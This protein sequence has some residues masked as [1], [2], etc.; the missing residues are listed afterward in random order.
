MKKLKELFEDLDL[1]DIVMGAFLL[2]VTFVLVSVALWVL[3]EA[4]CWYC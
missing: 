1:A 4:F 2:S 3:S